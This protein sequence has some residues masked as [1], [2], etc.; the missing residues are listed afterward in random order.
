M[1]ARTERLLLRPGWAEDAEML[2]ETIADELIVRNLAAAPW[3]YDQSHA[4]DFL[5]GWTSGQPTRFLMMQRTAADPR[6]IGGIGLEA[7]ADGGYELG[8]W[9]ARPYWGLG[10]ATEAGRHMV[11]LAR[12][13]GIR[14]LTGAPFIDNPASGAVLRKLGFRATGRRPERFSTARQSAATTVEYAHDLG[15][16]SDLTDDAVGVMRP[17]Q[18]PADKRDDWRLYAA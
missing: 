1:F 3:P 17:R 14:R 9:I 6:L 10:Y 15:P 18:W 7:T 16:C 8:Y 2:A 11:E 12:T 5:N 13:L 4:E